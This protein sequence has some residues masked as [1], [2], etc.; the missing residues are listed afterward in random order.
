M[1]QNYLWRLEDR[2]TFFDAQTITRRTEE[3]KALVAAGDTFRLIFRLRGGLARGQF[4]LCHEGLFNRAFA[5][6]KV[7]VVSPRVR[8]RA[9]CRLG[10]GGLQSGR[11]S[12]C[13][14]PCS[15]CPP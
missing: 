4:G 13:S 1:E 7:R 3:L 12:W 14:A 8:P 5:G 11:P 9:A 2:C 10:A 15:N 6:T